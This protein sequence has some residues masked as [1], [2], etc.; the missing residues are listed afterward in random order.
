MDIIRFV[1]LVDKS[2]EHA[3]T[4]ENFQA[5]ASS[6]GP[7][8]PQQRYLFSD[9]LLDPDPPR[10]QSALRL[11]SPILNIGFDDSKRGGYATENDTSAASEEW[12]RRDKVLA[13]NESQAIRETHPKDIAKQWQLF[14]NDAP[15]RPRHPIVEE[16]AAKVWGEFDDACWSEDNRGGN[17]T[18][19]E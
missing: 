17:Q 9:D 11:L 5:Q 14:A 16:T 1:E 19:W 18:K 10:K 13:L 3:S 12:G 8:L 6:S 15:A 2:F 4:Q 7:I